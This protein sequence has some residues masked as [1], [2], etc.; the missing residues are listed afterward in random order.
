MLDEKNG[1][2]EFLTGFIYPLRSFIQIDLTHKDK[3]RTKKKKKE[4]TKRRKKIYTLEFVYVNSVRVNIFANI[5]VVSTSIQC[6][7]E[8]LRFPRSCSWNNCTRCIALNCGA[9]PHGT[10]PSTSVRWLQTL[11]AR[12]KNVIQINSKLSQ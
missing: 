4:E 3:V 5:S 2:I 10:E 8:F 1:D 11:P 6:T 12:E 7:Y 9:A